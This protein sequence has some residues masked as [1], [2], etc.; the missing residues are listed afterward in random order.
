MNYLSILPQFPPDS[1][2]L[3]IRLRSLGDTILSTPLFAAMK[4]GRP[5]LELSVLVEE[6]NQEVLMGNP[7]IKSI[8]LLPSP[9]RRG[10]SLQTGKVRSLARIRAERFACC[11]NLHGGTT[12]AWLT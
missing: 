7:D 9:D 10:F 6:P 12:S 8:F 3:F 2:I 11:I 5:D 1:K 4:E